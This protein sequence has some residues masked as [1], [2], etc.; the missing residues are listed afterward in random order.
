M[1]RSRLPSGEMNTLR[2]LRTDRVLLVDAEMDVRR[3]HNFEYV[4]LLP[5]HTR[6]TRKATHS[7]MEPAQGIGGAY[8]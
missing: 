1:Q 7:K 5:R 2:I 4:V 3:Q 8:G 6:G